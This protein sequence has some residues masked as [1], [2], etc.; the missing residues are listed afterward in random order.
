[1]PCTCWTED[2]WRAIHILALTSSF[3][4]NE[5]KV[6]FCTFIISLNRII[7]CPEIEYTVCLF[8]SETDNDLINYIPTDT[9]DKKGSRERLFTWTYRL[10]EAICKKLNTPIKKLH[11]MMDFYK[12]SSITKDVWGPCIWK[13]IHT[14]L[15]RL[16][17]EDGIITERMKQAGKAFMV[18]TC[19]L[20]PCMKCR[21]HC[22]EYYS[23]H[24]INDYLDTNLHAFEW[25]VEF[26]NAVT[27]RTNQEN[28]YKRRTYTPQ[29]ALLIYAQ[30][31][32]NKSF[33]ECKF[34]ADKCTKH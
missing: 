7:S 31:P 18:C 2:I 17:M 12:K 27:E 30:V 29:E 26:H 33:L 1:M 6:A 8:M 20:L 3:K 22:W 10:R 5:E 13:L 16:K 4:Q 23:T 24:D 34:V 28:G 25:S 9:D 19:I 14:T 15:L 21:S 11:E 32:A